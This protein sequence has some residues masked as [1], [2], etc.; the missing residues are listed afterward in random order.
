MEGKTAGGGDVRHLMI[1]DDDDDDD[2]DDHIDTIV[3]HA[4]ATRVSIPILV[5]HSVSRCLSDVLMF[6]SRRQG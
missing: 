6:R 4:H 3:D 5:S 1:D 2:D